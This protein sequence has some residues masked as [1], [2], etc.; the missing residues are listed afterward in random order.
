M[1]EEKILAKIEYIIDKIESMQCEYVT[2]EEYEEYKER[3]TNAHE[4]AIKYCTMAIEFNSYNSVTYNIRA[5][6]Y[7]NLGQYEKAITDYSNAI[8]IKP[9]WWHY[10]FRGYCYKEL[11]KYEKGLADCNKTLELKPNHED[12]YIERG[13]CYKGLE[14][15][16]EAIADYT[17]IIEL[18]P[19]SSDC[20]FEAYEK[21]GDCYKELEQYDEAIFNY[22]RALRLGVI[23]SDKY[24]KKADCYR[25]LE[26]YNEAIEDYSKA[27]NKNS[28]GWAYKELAYIGRGLCY[29]VLHDMQN[30]VTD[31]EKVLKLTNDEN[32]KLMVKSAITTCEDFLLE[33]ELIKEKSMSDIKTI[34]KKLL[35]L[36]SMEAL[37]GLDIEEHKELLETCKKEIAELSD[38]ERY[39]LKARACVE[40]TAY[41]NAIHN[42]VIACIYDE[43]KLKEA[44][45]IL[46][47]LPDDINSVEYFKGFL[48]HINE[49]PYSTKEKIEYLEEN[50]FEKDVDSTNIIQ[51][52]YNNP[53]QGRKLD[54]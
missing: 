12:T 5:W 47:S 23:T 21:R 24:R 2:E 13:D 1:N 39:L 50:L 22:N 7:K 6:C 42:L 41:S 54:L 19:N 49:L 17:K 33:A 36:D 44:E 16:N 18:N 48:A 11:G 28:E 53:S 10:S 34:L 31:F 27:I 9:E 40:I 3:Y 45:I 32:T 15:Y 8:K 4:K 26:Q 30:A 37:E 43:S 51:Q 35:I 52:L 29:S 25:M 14:Q 46:S 38:S 20:R